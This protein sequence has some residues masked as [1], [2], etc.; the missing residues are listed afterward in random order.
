MLAR[1]HVFQNKNTCQGS[2]C[3][4]GDLAG[5]ERTCFIIYSS[6]QWLGRLIAELSGPPEPSP[7]S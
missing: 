7:A 4:A 3:F 1:L 2:I 5:N 6:D